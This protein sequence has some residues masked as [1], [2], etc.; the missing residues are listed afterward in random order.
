VVE[1]WKGEIA[2]GSY[3]LWSP[4]IQAAI[5]AGMPW[6]DVYLLCLPDEPC[7]RYPR[8]RPPSIRVCRRPGTRATVFMMSGLGA[9]AEIGGLHTFLPAAKATQPR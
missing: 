5:M 3:I 9:D 8:H 1:R 7:H 4:T 2:R 6:L